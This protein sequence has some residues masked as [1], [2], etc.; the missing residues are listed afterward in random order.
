MSQQKDLPKM[1]VPPLKQTCDQYLSALEPVVEPDDLQ[2]TKQLVEEFQKPGGVG[3]KLQRGLQ[4]KA[5]STD[6]WSTETYMKYLFLK[7]RKPLPIFSN[8]AGVIRAPDCTDIA[9]QLRVAADAI[10]AVLHYKLLID[11]GTLPVQYV[12]GFPM[13]N[14][15]HE[16]FISS[17]RIPHP[18][19]DSF[20]FF[21]KTP[22]PP[23]HITLIHNGQ[24][25]MMNVYHSDGTQ[26]S[27][28]EVHIQLQRIC[29]PS[30]EA[31]QE[32]VGVMTSQRRDIWGRVYEKLI[33][34]E[35]NRQ[36][37][38]TIQSSIFS[39]CLDGPS[40]AKI[41]PSQRRIGMH[42]M[43]TGEGSSCN[44]TNRWYDKG[45]QVVV[46]RNGLCGLQMSHSVADGIVAM[47]L[48]DITREHM[49]L[50]KPPTSPRE[51]LCPP[52]K[53]KFNITAE[54]KEDIQEAKQHADKLAKGFDLK[55]KDF[56]HFGKNFLKSL[57]MSPDSFVQMATQLA[58][59]RVHKQLPVTVEPVTLRMFKNGRLGVINTTTNE[60]V[61]FIK[62]F[63][64]PSIQSSEKV[65]LLKKA[66][67]VQSRNII[68]AIQGQVTD[69]H[70]FGL[71]MQAAEENIP[72]PEIFKD[73]NYEKCFA[74]QVLA[75]QIT[76]TSSNYPC[77]SP[78]TV[79]LYDINYG[80]MSDHMEF[81]VSCFE[82]SE[83]NRVKDSAKLI[84][85]LE[86]ALVDMGNLFKQ[87]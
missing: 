1:P 2:R 61:A 52:Q 13:C 84:Q 4:R 80:I 81:V 70:L 34:D 57:K 31:D 19:A 6:N 28:E 41:D 3:E 65:D 50:E 66:L 43:L 9:G 25:F 76:T 21:D 22:N 36:S 69:L 42:Q 73:A 29:D 20:V 32:P 85:A 12:Q 54:V 75:G 35:T 44:G 47:E 33:T 17:C 8:M 49:K 72:T 18:E 10:V 78:E 79:E 64:D 11:T 86:D 27:K 71:E 15:Q 82:Y 58:Y 74:C 48:M 67:K 55:L 53:L 87:S 63:D 30:Q 68:R 45:L 83:T 62:A 39:V 56:S 59:F 23:K 77:S 24:L 7:Q 51:D 46:G 5:E 37:L 38:L 14:M 16:N 60:S 26:L 40:P